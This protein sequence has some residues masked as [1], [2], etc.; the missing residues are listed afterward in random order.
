MSNFPKI[1]T[2]SLLTSWVFM[3]S[4]VAALQPDE[5]ESEAEMMVEFSPWDL[6]MAVAWSPKGDLISVS[7]GAWV[8]FYTFPE[9]EEIYR[10]YIGSFSHSLDFNAGGDL[11]AAGSRDGFVRVWRVLPVNSGSRIISLHKYLAHPKGVNSVSFNSTGKLLASGGNDAIAR[12]WDMD[13]GE[14][15]NEIIGGTFAVPA[16]LFITGNDLE[17]EVELA[18]INGGVLRLREPD[19]GRF[20]GTIRADQPFYSLAFST[21][22]SMLATGSI[23]NKVQLWDPSM[24]FR[25]GSDYLSST[26]PG[27]GPSW[28]TWEAWCIGVGSSF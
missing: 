18:V 28:R 4:T 15:V 25:T 13:T 7:A 1:L 5:L 6:V 9:L 17:S 8:Y 12:L 20:T 27:N 26:N 3:F 21:E 23:E 22:A 24:V 19:S 16:V 2:L 14:L 10:E 11:A